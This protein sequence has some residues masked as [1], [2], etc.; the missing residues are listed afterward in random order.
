MREE[1]QPALIPPRTHNEKVKGAFTAT[2]APVR[3]PE[4]MQSLENAFSSD[5]LSAWAARVEREG[6]AGASYLCELKVDGVAV[7]IVYENGRLVRAATRGDGTTGEDVTANVRTMENVPQQLGGEA[8]PE[9]LEVRG[10]I[11]FPV[12][13]FADVNAGMV[14]QGKAPF[15][16]PRNA[17]AGSLRQKDPKVTA[18]RPLRLV[19]HGIGAQRGFEFDRQ[20]AVYD[21]L[22]ELGLP[23]SSRYEVVDDLEGVWAYI[24]R[25]RE[26]RHSVEHEIDGVVVKVDQHALQRRLGS[27][28][29][30]PRWAIAFKYPPEEATTKLLD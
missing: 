21:R 11:Y 7:A 10:E 3:H 14:E 9:L 16:N 17:A 28:S 4:R 1:E 18:S 8:V 12:A 26:Q 13:A 15:A 22:R 30:A 6:G 20:S 29:R 19:I 24:E 27:T 5:E 25:Y 23:V 2:F